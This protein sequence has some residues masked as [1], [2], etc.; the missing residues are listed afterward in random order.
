[1]VLTGEN[2]KIK[3]SPVR[4]DERVQA[5]VSGDAIIINGKALD[6]SPV[7]EGGVLPREA[8]LS[9]WIA[10]DVL[11][12]DGEIN[13]TLVLPH[14]TNAPPETL[15]PVTYSEPVTVVDGPVPLPPYD[16]PPAVEDVQLPEIEPEVAP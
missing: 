2:M 6:F 5:E 12:V 4:T 10:S 1:M 3:L 7:P 8:I 13:L 16:A 9:P 14:G 15:F 11:R